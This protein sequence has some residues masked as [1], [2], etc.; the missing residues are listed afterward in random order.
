MH[1]TGETWPEDM[2]P[3]GLRGEERRVASKC[4][5]CNDTGHDP[6]CVS[7]CPQGCAYRVGSLDEIQGLLSR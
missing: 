5:L 3:T 1:A 7:N 6:A 4:D 2:V